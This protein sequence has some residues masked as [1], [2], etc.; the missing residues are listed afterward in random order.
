MR[1]DELLS[2]RL[3]LLQCVT[4][5]LRADEPVLEDERVDAVADLGLS[6]VGRPFEE[7]DVILVKLRLQLPFW[8]WAR[9]RA[10][11]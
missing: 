11:W 3:L 10:A 7:Q 9:Q 5:S 2:W 1:A 8:P 4:Y 6:G